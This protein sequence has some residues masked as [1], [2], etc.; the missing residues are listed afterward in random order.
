[1]PHR[2]YVLVRWLRV[3]HFNLPHDLRG[4]RRLPIDTL[5]LGRL[6]RRQ[7]GE[8]RFVRVGDGVLERQLRRRRLLRYR[9][10]RHVPGM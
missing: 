6:L 9:V 1:M 7:E 5:L 2:G 3:P 8:R 4:G 10:H